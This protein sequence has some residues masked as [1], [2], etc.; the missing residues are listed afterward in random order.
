MSNIPV[1]GWFN[2]KIGKIAPQ[3]DSAP[4][5]IAAVAGTFS[6]A[7]RPN[8]THRTISQKTSTIRNGSDTELPDFTNISLRACDKVFAS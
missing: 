1:N 5:N 3:T 6:C 4:R 2:S 8:L 7:N